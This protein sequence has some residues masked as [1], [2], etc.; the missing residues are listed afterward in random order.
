MN[1]L[2]LDAAK[3]G[4]LRPEDRHIDAFEFW[5]DRLVILK[6]VFDEAE[7]NSWSQWWYDRRKGVQRY[8]FLVAAVALALTVVFGLIQ[9]LEG[10]LQVYKAY[11]PS[12]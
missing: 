7:P 1:N 12:S 11:H 6:H 8:P 9:C 5:R 2:D 4:L 3:C 10:A